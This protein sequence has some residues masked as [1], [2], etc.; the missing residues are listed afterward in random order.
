MVR[1]SGMVKW[2]T[3]A[4]WETMTRLHSWDGR[5][6]LML[7]TGVLGAFELC[8]SSTQTFQK[9]EEHEEIDA[10]VPV[11]TLFSTRGTH[12]HF[13]ALLV[14]NVS[15]HAELAVP[16]VQCVWLRVQRASKPAMH[17][18]LMYRKST[19]SFRAMCAM[20]VAD[21]KEHPSI[22]NAFIVIAYVMCAKSIPAM[23]AMH[24]A[25]Y[26]SIQ[27]YAMLSLS[28]YRKS[29]KSIHAMCAMRLAE[30]KEHPSLPC[31]HY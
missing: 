23:C 4:K 21:C 20:C 25:E 17:T 24:L 15:K 19:K 28:M 12:P 26:K 9:Q 14:C 27:A 16:F 13:H 30:Y 3:M 5:H 2:R 31:L 11:V 8:H 10:W 7:D 1:R 29:T 6:S 22:C 18:L